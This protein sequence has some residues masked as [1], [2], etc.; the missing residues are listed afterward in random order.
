MVWVIVSIRNDEVQ[1]MRAWRPIVIMAQQIN[2]QSLQVV[3]ALDE[4]SRIRGIDQKRP[5]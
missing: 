3:L 1:R 2:Y 5:A 4:F